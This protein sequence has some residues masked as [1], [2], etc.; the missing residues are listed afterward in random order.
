MCVFSDLCILLTFSTLNDSVKLIWLMTCEDIIINTLADFV[1]QCF[2]MRKYAI[3][4]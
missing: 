3:T 1:F 2:K 4:Q